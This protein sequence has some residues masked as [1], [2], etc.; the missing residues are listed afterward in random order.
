MDPIDEIVD[1]SGP[2]DAGLL[3]TVVVRHTTSGGREKSNV[4]PPI[5]LELELLGADCFTNLVI[6]NREL[7]SER[8]TG[9]IILP[10]T[11]FAKLGWGSGVMAVYVNNHNGGDCSLGRLRWRMRATYKQCIVVS[12]P[13]VE[14]SVDLYR[15][16]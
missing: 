10:E 16:P 8:S 3:I 12:Q 13:K 6:G 11:P 15:R 14:R 2:L 1:C 7:L 9:T 5:L 4:R